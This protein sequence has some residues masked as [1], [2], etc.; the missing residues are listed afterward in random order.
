MQ[1]LRT[2]EEFAAFVQEGRAVVEFYATWCPDCKRIEPYLDAWAARF[3]DQFKMARL[4]FEHVPELSERLDI[5]GIPTF[6]AFENGQLVSRLYS[7]DAKSK[8]EV[9]AYLEQAYNG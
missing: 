8:E 1:E 7:R 5:R 6:L 2:E 4:N 3:Q 9:E